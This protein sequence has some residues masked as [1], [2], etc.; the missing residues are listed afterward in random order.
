MR[1]A[2]SLLALPVVVTCFA[3]VHLNKHM[4]V[5]IVAT[6]TTQLWSAKK[7]LKPDDSDKK[8]EKD[9]KSAPEDIKSAVEDAAKESTTALANIN[10]PSSILT[11]P[12]L[13]PKIPSNAKRLFL[14][15]HGEVIPPGG[16]HGVFYGAMDI[17]LSPLGK[18]EAGA[19][20]KFL[21]KYKL[22][23]VCSSPLKRAMYG[24][25]EVMLYQEKA[26]MH[27][28]M[29]KRMKVDHGFSELNR[30]TWCGK[31]KDQI[32]DELMAKFN[33]CDLSVTPR[34]GESYPVL[35]Q[36]VLTARDALLEITDA[37]RASCI[38]SHLQVTRAILADALD[39]P[40][41]QLTDIEVGTASISCV[42]YD[43]DTGEQTVHY[44]SFKPEVGLA[45]AQDGGNY[46]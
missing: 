37:G 46:V 27:E 35:C 8:K 40:T 26:F 6:T 28:T 17:P 2:F 33:S 30:G 23:Q 5:Q 15:R 18:A 11:D 21:Q 45:A 31:T 12:T 4:G 10:L 22:H 14:V 41:T 29:F 44:M 19:A 39:V 7:T 24:A 25:N 1:V 38:V 42:D 32:G 34:G 43:V 13:L 9:T 20:A 36:R 3:P 16:K